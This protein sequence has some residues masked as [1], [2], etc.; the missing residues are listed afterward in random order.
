MTFSSALWRFVMKS[1]IRDISS[2]KEIPWHVNLTKG[3]E[4]SMRLTWLE[5]YNF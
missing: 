4:V 2:T 3:I 5:L 1:E